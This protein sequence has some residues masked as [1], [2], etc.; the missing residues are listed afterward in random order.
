MRKVRIE[1]QARN[2]LQRTGVARRDGLTDAQPELLVPLGSGVVRHVGR[3]AGVSQRAPAR[4]AG[5]YSRLNNRTT[6]Y[7][8]MIA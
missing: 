7:Y 5:L 6:K 4:G 8:V 1:K 3:C 2:L